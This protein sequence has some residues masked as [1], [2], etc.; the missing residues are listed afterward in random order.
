MA[1]P[2]NSCGLVF[3]LAPAMLVIAA[4]LFSARVG[5]PP[6]A[7]LIPACPAPAQMFRP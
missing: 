4:G 7:K 2:G 1:N 6:G 5:A 3:R